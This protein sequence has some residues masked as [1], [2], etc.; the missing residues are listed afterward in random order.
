MSLVAGIQTFPVLVGRD[1]SLKRSKDMVQQM[2]ACGWG[3]L[4]AVL[5]RNL[6]ISW[7]LYTVDA[8]LLALCVWEV[9]NFD[10]CEA[11]RV[12]EG[13]LVQD[14]VVESEIDCFGDC[15]AK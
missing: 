15:V 13:V 3:D 7:G 5:Q 9:L 1:S 12:A 11:E 2:E 6:A 8:L 14:Q 10:W 4:A